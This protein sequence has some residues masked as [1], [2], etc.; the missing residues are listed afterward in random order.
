MSRGENNRF[1]EE[2]GREDSR[3]TGLRFNLSDPAIGSSDEVLHSRDTTLRLVSYPTK[4]SRQQLFAAL[5]Q[6][7]LI[8]G[9]QLP[10]A[11]AGRAVFSVPLSARPLAYEVGA[12]SQGQFTYGDKRLF[13][14]LGKLLAITTHTVGD[15]VLPPDSITK[16]VAFV[17]FTRPDEHNLFLVPGVEGVLVTPDVQPKDYYLRQ[18]P[19][20]LGDRFHP[21][22]YSEFSH[23]F[24]TV[25]SSFQE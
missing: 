16:C 19:L 20:E 8:L 24:D 25:T 22:A 1:P 13:G 15:L 17:D 6:R 2:G 3:P 10:D 11:H 9:V 18:L 4:Y 21:L 14:E 5:K 7:Q 12:A 23:A